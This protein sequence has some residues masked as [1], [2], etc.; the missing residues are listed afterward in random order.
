MTRSVPLTR[1]VP[2]PP[3]LASARQIQKSI[4]RT[5]S[6]SQIIVNG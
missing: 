2:N 3:D 6:T 5:S 1:N 4:A